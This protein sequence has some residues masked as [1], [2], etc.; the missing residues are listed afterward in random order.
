MLLKAN[1]QDICR[2]FDKK[3]NIDEVNSALTQIHE[4]MDKRAGL[5]EYNAH[6]SQQSLILDALCSENTVGR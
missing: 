6:L 4:E 3:A 2:L 1:L 5:E